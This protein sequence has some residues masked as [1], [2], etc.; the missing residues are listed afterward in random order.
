MQIKK[1]R[2]FNEIVY[3]VFIIWTIPNNHQP[4]GIPISA[5][6]N[7]LAI[8]LNYFYFRPVNKKKSIY[9]NTNH[10]IEFQLKS[11]NKGI[12]EVVTN[13]NRNLSL[14]MNFITNVSL[15]S[16]SKENNLKVFDRMY[17]RPSKLASAICISTYICKSNKILSN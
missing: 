13:K 14:T 15:F 12:F 4:R 10:K 5:D 17:I 7:N 16:I 8:Q 1:N 9:H 11:Y 2:G 3:E 6:F